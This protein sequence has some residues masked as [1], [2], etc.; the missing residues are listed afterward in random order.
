MEFTNEQLKEIEKQFDI[1]AGQVGVYLAR[2]IFSLKEHKKADKFIN[3]LI[4]EAIES[5]DA[6]RTISAIADKMQKERK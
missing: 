5:F 1:L 3:K 4:D 2:V 6:Y